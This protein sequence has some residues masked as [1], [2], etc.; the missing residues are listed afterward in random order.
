MS[1]PP[2]LLLPLGLALCLL[3]VA[4]ILTDQGF[5]DVTKESVCFKMLLIS[6]VPRNVTKKQCQGS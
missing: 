4:D 2:T 5:V 3:V 6:E 1:V